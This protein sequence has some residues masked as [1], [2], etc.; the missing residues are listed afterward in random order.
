MN[1]FNIYTYNCIMLRCP[2]FTE[3]IGL[4]IDLSL[5][6]NSY[7]VCLH[8]CLI[9]SSKLCYQLD[10]KT[11]WIIVHL[12]LPVIPSISEGIAR[13]DNFRHVLLKR[14]LFF[15]ISGEEKK[16]LGVFEI[17]RS[18][19][20]IRVF[21]QIQSQIFLRFIKLLNERTFHASIFNFHCNIFARSWIRHFGGN[22]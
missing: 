7:T 15:I 5:N 21:L 10:I 9:Q 16:P 18:A 2:K 17:S 14:K 12:F 11:L 19:C 1:K 22:E 3:Y 20:K 13:K 8:V 6:R 4:Q